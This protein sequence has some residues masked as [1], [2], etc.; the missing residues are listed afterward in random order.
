MMKRR[1]AGPQGEWIPHGQGEKEGNQNHH[2][3]YMVEYAVAKTNRNVHE[4]AYT[5]EGA[6]REAEGRGPRKATDDK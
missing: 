2:M 3:L 6:G 5:R 1:H 4:G